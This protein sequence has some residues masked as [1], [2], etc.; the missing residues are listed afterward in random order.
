MS[1]AIPSTA[2]SCETS[3]KLTINPSI[4]NADKLFN[5]SVINDIDK[6]LAINPN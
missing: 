6:K 4:I 1:I 3:K 2:M 5:G